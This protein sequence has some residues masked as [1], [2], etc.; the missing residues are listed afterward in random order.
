LGFP[1]GLDA[2]VS[3]FIA[4]QTIYLNPG[5]VIVLY[6][7]GITEAENIESD[8]YGLERLCEVICKNHQNSA[9]HIRQ[10]IVTDVQQYIGQQQVFD[11]MTVVVIKQK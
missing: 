11:D 9:E 7:D 2:D 8:Q 4:Q 1:I 6:T 5:D 10:A 3:E